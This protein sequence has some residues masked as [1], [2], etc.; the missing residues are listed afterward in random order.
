[1][2]LCCHCNK[3]FRMVY[4]TTSYRFHSSCNTYSFPPPPPRLTRRSFPQHLDPPADVLD[5]VSIHGNRFHH[6]HRS[7]RRDLGGGGGRTRKGRYFHCI[8]SSGNI[9]I[10]VPNTI[11]VRKH[12][13]A[14]GHHRGSVNPSQRTSFTLSFWCFIYSKFLQHQYLYNYTSWFTT[15]N[16]I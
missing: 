16:M 7:W 3:C 15:A 11:S 1:M 8:L 12:A 9:F 10:R 13:P 4:H 14:R 6:S 2:L 5:L